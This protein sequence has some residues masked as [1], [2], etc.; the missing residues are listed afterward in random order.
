M[1]SKYICIYLYSIF[2][3]FLSN[4]VLKGSESLVPPTVCSKL[5]PENSDPRS[6]REPPKDDFN[7]LSFLNSGSIV[8]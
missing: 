6:L 8:K 3:P 4:L 5:F 2:T 1:L 7:M